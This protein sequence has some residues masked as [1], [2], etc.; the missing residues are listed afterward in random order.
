LA[1]AGAIFVEEGVMP[2]RLIHETSPYLLQHAHNPVDWYPWGDEAFA[3]ARAEDKP[4]LL[5]IGY[6]A[7]HW[8]HV[9]EH[10]SFEDEATAALM[11]ERFVSIKVD[12]EERPDLDQIYMTAVQ[13]L[14]GRGGWPMTVFLTPDGKPFYGGTYYPPEDRMG[15]PGFRRVLVS[16]SDAYGRERGQVTLQAERLAAF[17]QEQT[18]LHAPVDA[19]EA[20]VLDDAFGA[21]TKQ[22]DAERGGFG[23]PPKFPQAM[24]IEFLLGYHYRTRNPFALQM[25]EL[26][27]RRMADGGIY[28]QIGGGFHRY[29][30]DERWLVPHF[31]KMLY[32]NAL[33]ARAFLHA[34]QVTGHERYRSVVEETL[35]YVRREMVDPSGG[36]FSTQDADSEGEEGKYYIW[37]PEELEAEL[38][39][40]DAAIAA[41]FYGV[42]P[43]GNFEHKTILTWASDPEIIAAEQG[44][45]SEQLERRVADIRA[46]M[47]EART[48]RVP[49]ARD[50]KILSAWNGLMLRTFAEAARALRRPEDL[51]TAE[52]CAE[53]LA[54]EMWRDGR[55][56][57][58]HKDG[59]TRITGY[60]DDYAGVA[61]ALIALYETTFDGRW[62][63]TAR[64]IVDAMVRL[65]WD[66]ESTA[67]FDTAVDAEALLARPRDFW[68]N[69]TPSGTSLA[70]H[71]LL[72]L[73]ALTGE[74]EYERLARITLSS[75]ATG[76]RQHPSGL[77][78][79]LSA[80]VLYL[81]PPREV[82]IIG[83]PTSSDTRALIEAVQQ[84]YL[85]TAVV[86]AGTAD[87]SPAV[88][89]LADRGLVDGHAAAYVCRDFVCELPVTEPE[90]LVR[91]LES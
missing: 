19:L 24:A 78:N 48:H 39:S 1:S 13:G 82:A 80:L 23:G 47:L 3:R 30:V 18:L 8:C 15:M 67:F 71:A 88:P 12:R 72:R 55:M 91:Q 70:C 37:A 90:A 11:N 29:S 38:G 31:E 75:L 89:L 7:C 16:V 49:P 4:L 85:P 77:G 59:Q 64:D 63:Q 60:L 26:T 53:F 81:G 58:V 25:V 42:R 40:K 36:F 6:S 57:R 9:M 68:D 45:S 43:G 50:D 62:L 52:R 20:G 65:F 44:L 27:L 51:V 56:Y 74:A 69:A 73:W 79:L 61:D 83:N 28:D 14:T 32:D 66:A 33:L 17:V 35:D 46:R 54:S 84:R 10:E 76:M 34:Y 87:D 21:L 5:S 22:F 2:N 86:A 41:S